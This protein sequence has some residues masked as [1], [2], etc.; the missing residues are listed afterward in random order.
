MAGYNFSL[1]MSNNAVAAYEDGVKP[2]SQICLGDLQDA[3]LTITLRFAKWL[4]QR[5]FW[6][7]YE[8]HHSGGSYF[9]RVK[10]YDPRHLA[11]LVEDGDLDLVALQARFRAEKQAVSP[12]DEGLNVCGSFAV[13]ER[14]NGR[15]VLARRET[16]QGTKIG[17]WIYLEGG[18]KKKASGRHISWVRSTEDE[19]Q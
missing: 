12:P 1:G 16:F 4:A 14:R 17:D 7:S 3:G 9:N 18:G 10:F 15:N 2:L 19:R 11:E 8:W 13:W 6:R 5:G